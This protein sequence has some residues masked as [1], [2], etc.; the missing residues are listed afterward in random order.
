MAVSNKLMPT[1]VKYGGTGATTAAGAVTNLGFTQNI[2]VVS[3]AFSN[4]QTGVLYFVVAGSG[5][6]YTVESI[7]F[8]E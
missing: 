1:D 4:F 8:E 3:T 2:Q 7:H 5:P 6:N